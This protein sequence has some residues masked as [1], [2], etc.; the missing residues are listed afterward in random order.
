MLVVCI[1]MTLFGVDLVAC[2]MS[3]Y[4]DTLARKLD[5]VVAAR[6]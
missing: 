1:R 5:V 2:P 6:L 4:P 3:R